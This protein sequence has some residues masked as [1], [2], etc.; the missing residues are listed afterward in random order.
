MLTKADY[1]HFQK[2][3]QIAMLSDSFRIHI[4]CVAIYQGNVIG[5]GYNC[6]KTHPMQQYY[7]R[8]RN[9]FTGQLPT[10][11]AEMNC[12]KQIKKLNVNFSKVQLYIYRIRKDQPFGLSRPCPSCMAAIK[13]LGIQDI[14]YT[15]NDGY[16]YERIQNND[17][18]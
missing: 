13:D 2:A 1:K 6:N 3:R 10:L 7:N 8:Y 11:H 5:I 4:G 14:H 18:G 9:N 12:I 16:A 17:R 15:T